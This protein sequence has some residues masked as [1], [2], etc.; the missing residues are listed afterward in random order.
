MN[1]YLE[2]VRLAIME[3]HGIDEDTALEIIE[4]E[5]YIYYPVEDYDEFI[6]M[7]FDDGIFGEIPTNLINYLDYEK[8][9]RDLEIDGYVLTST[10]I[11]KID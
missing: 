1:D 6:D 8:I 2:N 5:S 3:G 11:I 4:D 9:A 10:G 7:L